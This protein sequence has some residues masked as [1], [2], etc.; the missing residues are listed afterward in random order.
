MYGRTSEKS[1]DKESVC[2][3]EREQHTQKKTHC[4]Y[5]PYDTNNVCVLE[6]TQAFYYKNTLHSSN[7]YTVVVEV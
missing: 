7:C 6:L 2:D 5:Y 1:V 3:A 4:I